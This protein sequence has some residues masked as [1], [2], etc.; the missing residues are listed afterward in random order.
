M[1]LTN[2]CFKDQNWSH[3]GEETVEKKREEKERRRRRGRGRGRK[4]IKQAKIKR[5]GT[6]NLELELGFLVWILG[7]VWLMV[8]CCTQT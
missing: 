4:E 3:L 8:I 6:T 2:P 1:A 5:Y 7:C